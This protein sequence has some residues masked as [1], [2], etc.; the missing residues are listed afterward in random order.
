VIVVVEDVTTTDSQLLLMSSVGSDP[1]E[2]RHRFF[3]QHDGVPPYFGCQYTAYLNQHY[4]N[5]LI[6]YRG[7]ML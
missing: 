1:L 7:P 2:T 4:E 5:H 6:G 3:F